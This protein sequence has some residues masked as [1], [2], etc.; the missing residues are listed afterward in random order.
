MIKRATIAVAA[1]LAAAP[2]NAEPVTRP[3]AVVKWLRVT[4]APDGIEQG[5]HTIEARA[6]D[7]QGVPASAMIEVDLGPP[8]TASAGCSGEDVCVMGTCLPGPA[9]PG[10][11]GDS[12]TAPTECLGAQCV[13]DAK[14]KQCVE[15]CDLGA[16]NACPNDF[17]C[18][19]AGASGVCWYNGSAG[20]CSAS[21]EPTGPV[22]LGASVF[23]LL[24]LRR[25][26]RQ[27]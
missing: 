2:A 20:C 23:G 4:S 5:A 9:V 25:R 14:D 7:V 3:Q 6:I 26:R 12:C 11:L 13:G 10:G 24:L 21:T 27:P 8:C 1:L 17:S 16:V 15:S 18:I 22:L 19:A